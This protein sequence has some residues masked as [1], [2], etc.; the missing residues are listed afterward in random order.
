MSRRWWRFRR[1]CPHSSCVSVTDTLHEYPQRILLRITSSGHP[2]TDTLPDILPE[3]SRSER[4]DRG[5]VCRHYGGKHAAPRSQCTWM[6]GDR[7]LLVGSVYPRT[8]QASDC[9]AAWMLVDRANELA[10]DRAPE[11]RHTQKNSVRN[12]VRW[13]AER[14]MASPQHRTPSNDSR[15]RVH[16]GGGATAAAATA[17]AFSLWLAASELGGG[18]ESL[19]RSLARCRKAMKEPPATNIPAELAS[20]LP[21]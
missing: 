5:C 13:R 3:D 1:S 6:H 12:P 11:R 19:V 7:W 15:L 8:K 21:G 14:A 10:T 18:Y 4:G 16:P 20:W 2:Y 17:A 9:L